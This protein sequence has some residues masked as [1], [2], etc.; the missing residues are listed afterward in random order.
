MERISVPDAVT[1][2]V[3]AAAP[4]LKAAVASLDGQLRAYLRAAVKSEDERAEILQDALAEAWSL[5]S[6]GATIDVAAV[7][8]MSLA[9][10]LASAWKSR[11]RHEVFVSDNAVEQH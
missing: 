8:S 3:T 2:D 5:L 9:R 10:R 6:D 1:R 4:R 7:A 11:A